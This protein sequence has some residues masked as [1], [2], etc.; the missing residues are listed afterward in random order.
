[1]RCAMDCV[2]Y[3]FKLWNKEYIGIIK[4]L[5]SKLS[6]VGISIF[7][8]II[9]LQEQSLEVHAY[10]SWFLPKC[11]NTILY[12]NKKGVFHYLIL[13]RKSFYFAWIYDPVLGNIKIGK[14]RLYLLW[15]HKYIMCYNN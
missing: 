13:K 11:K 10:H 3:L 2:E 14:W 9:C 12:L 6:P 1:M 4:A 7:D 5:E 15:S 8:L